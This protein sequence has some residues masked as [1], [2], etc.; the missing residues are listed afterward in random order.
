MGRRCPRS[1][2]VQAA[3][4]QELKA[5]K[6][7]AKQLNARVNSRLCRRMHD[8]MMPTVQTLAPRTT[9]SGE[10]AAFSIQVLLRTTQAHNIRPACLAESSSPE[11]TRHGRPR[12]AALERGRSRWAVVTPCSECVDEREDFSADLTHLVSYSVVRVTQ[13]QW[14]S[15]V[16]PYAQQRVRGAARPVARRAL[17]DRSCGVPTCCFAP[18]LPCNSLSQ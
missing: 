1:A 17:C 8:H 9:L 15:S 4:K 2:H 10:A 7:L 16:Q 11:L 12:S 14:S 3:G 18:C 13:A 6:L 5:L